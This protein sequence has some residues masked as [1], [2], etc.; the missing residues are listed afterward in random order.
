[1]LI[2]KSKALQC[3]TEWNHYSYVS[4]FFTWRTTLLW[5]IIDYS[6]YFIGEI[7]RDKMFANFIPNMYFSC[8]NMVY[9]NLNFTQVCRNTHVLSHLTHY[10]TS[11][12]GTHAHCYMRF[13]LVR[14]ASEYMQHSRNAHHKLVLGLPH[15]TCGGTTGTVCCS[16]LS[17]LYAVMCI[18][19]KSYWRSMVLPNMLGYPHV[20]SG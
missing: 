7:S 1:M 12:T 11:K 9:P 3:Y 8:K 15:Y 13:W 16:W 20:I 14:A 5:W 6:C 18:A 17:S 19:W 2:S 4:C 10:R